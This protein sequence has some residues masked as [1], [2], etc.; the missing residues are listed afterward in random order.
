MAAISDRL[1]VV[2]DY[3][4]SVSQMVDEAKEHYLWVTDE[5]CKADFPIGQLGVAQLNM[6]IVD[7][8]RTSYMPSADLAELG[9]REATVEELLAFAVQHRCPTGIH[10]LMASGSVWVWFY[11][12]YYS[13]AV[14]GTQIYMS[15]RHCDGVGRWF[16]G[17]EN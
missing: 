12:F 8:E 14:A 5:L 15:P 2:V 7:F 1:S 16:L 6:R 17:V 11:G 13:P 10:D 3:N 9:M 4:K